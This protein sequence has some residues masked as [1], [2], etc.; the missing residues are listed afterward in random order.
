MPS[1][2]RWSVVLALVCVGTAVSAQAEQLK[3][4]VSGTPPFVIKDGSHYSGI[5]LDVWR[6]IAED[7]NLNY[8]L[9]QQPHAKA[10]IAAVNNG[11]IDVLVGPISITSSRLAIPGIDFTQPYF[12][13]KEG[14]L[15]PLSLIHI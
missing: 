10:G 1:T 11:S 3:V 14:I 12:L 2:R 15:L 7:N 13:S 9:I 8:E 6:R 5:S 4:G